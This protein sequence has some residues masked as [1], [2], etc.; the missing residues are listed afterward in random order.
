V[1][2]TWSPSPTLFLPLLQARR[3]AICLALV[4]TVSSGCSGA[5]PA[6][7]ATAEGDA[8]IDAVRAALTSPTE[9]VSPSTARA[10]LSQWQVFQLAKP[11]LES[12]LA[13]AAPPASP[14]L[15]GSASAGEYDLGC[16]TAGRMSGRLT[17]ASRVGSEGEATAGDGGGPGLQGSV[18]ATLSD[19]CVGDTCLDADV[20]VDVVPGD[21]AALATMAVT[22]SVTHAGVTEAFSL[23][24]QGGMGRGELMPRVAFFDD[25]GGSI[26]VGGDAPGPYLVSGADQSFECSV[27]AGGGS[28]EGATTFT[29]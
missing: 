29:F 27:L 18:D 13:I 17:F 23:G 14:C 1:N 20:A 12:I 24:A 7:P 8:R 19:A 9:T 4:A 5:S 6:G 28:C 3:Q 16:L 25:S 10:V 2:P 26:V 22:A 11:A 15:H 21:C